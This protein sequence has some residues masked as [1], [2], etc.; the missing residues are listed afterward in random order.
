M[1]NKIMRLPLA[2]LGHYIIVIFIFLPFTSIF[3]QTNSQNTCIKPL[4][5]FLEIRVTRVPS[6]SLNSSSDEFGNSYADVEVNKRSAYKLN[7]P[8]VMKKK[9]NVFLGLRYQQEEF[10]FRNIQFNRY[11]VYQRL[12]DRSLKSAG[13][14]LYIQRKLDNNQQIMLRIGGDLNGDVIKAHHHY[15]KHSYTFIYTKQKNEFTKI[16]GGLAFGYDMGVPLIYPL[17]IYEHYFNPHFSMELALPKS[18]NFAYRP[19]DKCG[20]NLGLEVRGAS[21]H[22]ENEVLPEY[23]QVELRK[24]ELR[25]AFRLERQIYDFIWFG[26]EI[27]GTQNL[28][29][30]LS[31]PYKRR[32]ESII[33]ANGFQAVFAEF[34]LFLVPPRR[35]LERKSR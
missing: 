26:A 34:S 35:L 28:N 25:L 20:L 33:Q 30:F 17:F 19:N 27:G 22:L 3:A 6:F 14:R 13:L 8:L 21:Y 16:G 23:E 2:I 18:V 10:E 1:Q 9:T 12:E 31:E 15:L 11:P 32:R 5:R 24:S 7:L 4:P 29:L